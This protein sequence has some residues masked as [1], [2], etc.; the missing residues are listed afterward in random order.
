M[1]VDVR[2]ESRPRPG[3]TTS[4]RP[5]S[6]AGRSRSGA[7]ALSD[8]HEVAESWSMSPGLGMSECPG[9]RSRSPA[10]HQVHGVVGI[11]VKGDDF[12]RP[13]T[14]PVPR[15]ETFLAGARVETL[16]AFAP[17]SGGR[18]ER[19]P[20]DAGGRPDL[21]RSIASSR[22][23]LPQVEAPPRAGSRPLCF[24]VARCAGIERLVAGGRVSSC[25]RVGIEARIPEGRVVRW[26]PPMSPVLFVQRIVADGGVVPSPVRL[27][28]STPEPS[29]GL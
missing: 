11:D 16:Y 12:G 5:A 7:V 6:S 25:C 8:V 15:F 26:S 28:N 13:P 22:C 17:T 2:S 3:A 18:P 10:E 4:F 21:P 23:F 9:R 24:V 20:G 19:R 29:P 27:L 1:P 14:S